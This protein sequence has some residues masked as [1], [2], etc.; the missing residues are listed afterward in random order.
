MVLTRGWLRSAPAGTRFRCVRRFRES[1]RRTRPRLARRDSW[2]ARHYRAPPAVLRQPRD[3][4]HV[5]AR[6]DQKGGPRTA[7]CR[8]DL[9]LPQPRRTRPRRVGR[10]VATPAHPTR[11]AWLTDQFLLKPSVRSAG[12]LM[13]HRWTSL[14]C[15]RI[16]GQRNEYPVNPAPLDR[17][18]PVQRGG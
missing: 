11:R 16:M 6:L 10:A 5:G 7:V 1:R 15:Q 12:R 2:L 8:G 3:R 18:V 17:T 14:I 13:G 4:Y 9:P